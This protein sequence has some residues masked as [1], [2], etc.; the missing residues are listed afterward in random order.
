M[1]RNIAALIVATAILP[2][3]REE[4]RLDGSAV[5]AVSGQLSGECRRRP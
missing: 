2:E 1:T 5:G 3:D 4:D